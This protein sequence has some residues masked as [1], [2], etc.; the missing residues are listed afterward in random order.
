MQTILITGGSG[1][2]GGTLAAMARETWH[3]VATF[4][5]RDVGIPGV[6]CVPLD[7][8]RSDDV[9]RVVCDAAPE[10]IVHAAALANFGAC[11]E[12]PAAARAVNVEGTANV[13]RAAEQAGARL[14]HLSTDLVF[15]GD[16]GHYSE[17]DIPAPGCVYGKTKYEADCVVANS[18]L[19]HCIGRTSLVYGLSSNSAGCFAEAMLKTLS[20]GEEVV[21]YTDEY[22]TQVYVL[23][24]CRALLEMASDNRLQG[25][26][27]LCCSDRL[28]RYEFGVRM[29][30][31]LEFDIGLLVPA[32]SDSYP[33]K[34]TR[35][36][37]C[38]LVSHPEGPLLTTRFRGVTEGLR[39]MK[40]RLGR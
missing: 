5:S 36:K 9:E 39:D 19:S 18:G 23:D 2:L 17:R 33:G 3:T 24:V 22:R 16:T 10:V 4:R 1:F 38:S 6:T 26:Y 30:E 25:L 34:D 7:I 35:P 13:A 11:P 15:D 14:V 12:D 8:A 37:D 21:L 20:A 31:V 40:R 27:H 32:S 28:S 29:C